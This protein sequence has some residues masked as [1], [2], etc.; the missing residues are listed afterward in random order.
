[1]TANTDIMDAKAAAQYLGIAAQT[2][3]RG[4]KARDLR[5]SNW[6]R[7]YATPSAIWMHGSPR[8]VAARRPSPRSMPTPN[9]LPTLAS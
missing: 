6:A 9:N 3:A 5:I 2:L 7:A 1:M 4:W 8:D